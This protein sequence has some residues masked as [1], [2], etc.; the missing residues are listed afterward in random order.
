M[1]ER[2]DLPE[3]PVDSGNMT[4]IIDAAGEVVQS[5]EPVDLEGVLTFLGIG[6][7]ELEKNVL[8]M[9]WGEFIRLA[10][11]RAPEIAI[12]RYRKIQEER[13]GGV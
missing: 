2:S 6:Q 13:N 9:P 4:A 10:G 1:E 11:D 12:E 5:N 7:E 8:S 3:E